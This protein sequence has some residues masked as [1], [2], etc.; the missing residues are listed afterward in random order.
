M[1]APTSPP[2]TSFD[3]DHNSRRVYSS[4][5]EAQKAGA[6]VAG[7]STARAIQGLLH[8]DDCIVFSKIWC[9][10][11]LFAIISRL[12]PPDVV[13]KLEE[14]GSDIDFLHAHIRCEDSSI[15]INRIHITPLTPNLRFCLGETLVPKVAKCQQYVEGV[16]QAGHLDL[17]LWGKLAIIANTCRNNFNE[18]KQA[19][20]C[21]FVEPILL[22]WNP[23][24]VG[25]C[26]ANFP[27]SHRGRTGNCI[28]LL[29]QTI[30]KSYAFAS[31]WRNSPTW[32]IYPWFQ[33]IDEISQHVESRMSC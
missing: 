31:A 22:G 21:T 25:I 11:C 3:L 6:Y 29:G 13:A 2:I 16:H 18:A 26:A 9:E 12:W 17:I 1:G 10:T 15:Y 27:K 23:K 32:I 8:V 30:K 20:L 4:K 19:I 24:T 33:R 5:K 28:R 7:C 14:R